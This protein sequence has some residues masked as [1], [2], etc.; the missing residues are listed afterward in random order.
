MYKIELLTKRITKLYIDG[1]PYD[2]EWEGDKHGYQLALDFARRIK[3]QNET[4][5]RLTILAAIEIVER[6]EQV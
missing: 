1:I 2:G 6:Y 5:K 4:L 3:E